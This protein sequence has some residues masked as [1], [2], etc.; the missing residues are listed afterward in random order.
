[1]FSSAYIHYT[2]V[3]LIIVC[4]LLFYVFIYYIL[5]D[6]VFRPDCRVER[7]NNLKYVE[8]NG[9]SHLSGGTEANHN[10]P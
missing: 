8:G 7:F 1:M 10:E 5:H 6:T 3:E 4:T 2:Y 9:H